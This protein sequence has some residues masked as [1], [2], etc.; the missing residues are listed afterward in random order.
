MNLVR[1]TGG[2][3]LAL[4]ALAALPLGAGPAPGAPAKPEAK[5]AL[6]TTEVGK[7]VTL[8]VK[9]KERRVIVKA[10]VVLREG[11]LEGLLTR[12]MTKEHEYILA[13]DC[14]ARHIHVALT[15]AGAKAGSPVTFVPKYAPA[16]GSAIRASLRYKKGGKV[17][18][19]PASEWVREHRSKKA[20]DQD[21]V[22]AGSRFVENPAGQDKPRVYVANYGDLICLC[23]MD[24]AMLDLP[25]KSPKKFDARMYE[26]VTD[27]IPPKD[28]PVEVILEVVP[29]KKKG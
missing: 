11:Q 23:N 27:R 13:A 4:F 29:P 28:T 8:E 26:A 6:K 22:F 17:V 15:L 2:L 3:L 20:L 21:W 1:S 14:D 18:T 7:N 16:H 24:T 25:V 12:A 9:G 5:P 19:V 10:V